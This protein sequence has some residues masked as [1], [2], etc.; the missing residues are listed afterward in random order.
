MSSKK[1][2]SRFNVGL[3]SY[4]FKFKFNNDN[5]QIRIYFVFEFLLEYTIQQR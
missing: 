1:L 3:L 2:R 5:I 4:C